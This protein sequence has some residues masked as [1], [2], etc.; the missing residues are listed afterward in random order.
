MHGTFSKQRTVCK[1]QNI[2]E[3]HTKIFWVE[4]RANSFLPLLRKG[5]ISE[6]IR[7][8]SAISPRKC[9]WKE[10]K[11]DLAQNELD[12]IRA[13][14]LLRL[15]S[16]EREEEEEDSISRMRGEWEKFA[17]NRIPP[18][19]SNWRHLLQFPARATHK[20]VILLLLP[21][22]S[23]KEEEEQWS[24][25]LLPFF[26]SDSDYFSHSPSSSFSF[27]LLLCR[28]PFLPSRFNSMVVRKI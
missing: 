11:K 28:L 9:V 10:K 2:G 24:F 17:N 25:F 4:S 16:I 8:K 5:D 22:S 21:L 13:L 12:W 18:S 23:L 1:M 27:P 15:N 19:L 6:W 14:L 7:R 3:S 20:G 26:T